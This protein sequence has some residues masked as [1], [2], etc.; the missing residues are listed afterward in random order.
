M[1]LLPE[2]ERECRQLARLRARR[3]ESSDLSIIVGFFGKT[4]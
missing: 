2:A 3:I 1:T 4:C